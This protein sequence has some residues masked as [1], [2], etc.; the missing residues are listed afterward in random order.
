MIF[1]A[2]QLGRQVREAA[3]RAGL[4]VVAFADND[5]SLWGTTRDG[6]IVLA[7][8]E[9]VARF[10]AVA[11]CVVAIFNPSRPLRQLHEL[12]GRA[13]TSYPEFFWSFG[14]FVPGDHR[15]GGAGVDRRAT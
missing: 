4:E 1:G 11:T 5:E 8:A 10:N 3:A 13:I 9:A 7:P 2:G 14:E 6:V 15:H 12:G